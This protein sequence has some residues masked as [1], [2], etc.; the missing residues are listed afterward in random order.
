M[1]D[2]EKYSGKRGICALAGWVGSPG[3]RRS[4][5]VGTGATNKKRQKTSRDV[6]ARPAIGYPSMKE[7]ESYASTQSIVHRERKFKPQEGNR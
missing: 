6:F 5:C 1:A 2:T 7:D 4:E 3:I